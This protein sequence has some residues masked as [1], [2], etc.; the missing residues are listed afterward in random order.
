MIGT[1]FGRNEWR[2]YSDS[3]SSYQHIDV[4]F[5]EMEQATGHYDSETYNPNPVVLQLAKE[6]AHPV[7]PRQVK[8]RAAPKTRKERI[9]LCSSL[10]GET[11]SSSAKN[12]SIQWASKTS[13]PHPA[14]CVLQ[15]LAE[16]AL[17]QHS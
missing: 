9:P 11:K 10:H 15:V 17:R 6:P 12:S 16:Q 3:T 5:V 8:Q 4:V 1:T 2:P 14:R 13:L 7:L